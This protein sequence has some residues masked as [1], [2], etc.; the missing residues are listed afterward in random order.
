M[1]NP[2]NNHTPKS[3]FSASFISLSL[4]ASLSSLPSETSQIPNI[5]DP[6]HDRRLPPLDPTERKHNGGS[7]SPSPV[8][9][10]STP[11]TP[12]PDHG[13]NFLFRVGP[14]IQGLGPDYWAP[15]AAGHPPGLNGLEFPDGLLGLARV[16]RGR[17][18]RPIRRTAPVHCSSLPE[19]GFP[20]ARA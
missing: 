18:P 8:I 13:H 10:I 1:Q 7:Q 15:T 4:L 5:P 12:I 6:P 19:P 9:N 14:T 2:C 11:H 3:S 17:I 20:P 16:G